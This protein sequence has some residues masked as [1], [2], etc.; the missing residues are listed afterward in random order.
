[1]VI[2]WY[3][4][5]SFKVQSGSV[6]IMTDPFEAGTGLNVPRFKADIVLKTGAPAAYV[7]E[8]DAQGKNIIG[9]GEYEVKGVEV[10]GFGA[11]LGAV[12]AVKTEDM[13]LAFLGGLANAELSADALEALS[14]AEILFVPAGGAPY[15]EPADAAKLIKKL[16]PKIVIPCF[17]KIPGLKRVAQDLKKFEEVL[18]QKADKQEKLTIKAKDIT[19][20][21]TKLV[22]LGV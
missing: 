1:M 14:G 18:G 21:G 2:N 9:P 11:G 16:E 3:G 10:M 13:K 7:S 19:W 15:I 8:K 4:E 20:Q 5:G 6:A 12:Y 22:A 17:Y